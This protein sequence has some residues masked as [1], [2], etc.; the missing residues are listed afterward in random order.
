MPSWRAA[1]QV[2]RGCLAEAGSPARCWP[3]ATGRGWQQVRQ[4]ERHPAAQ[5]GGN[6]RIRIGHFKPDAERAAAGVE[7]PID[8][9]HQGLVFAADR[10]L[11]SDDGAITFVDLSI[12]TDRS[13]CDTR[14][15]GLLLS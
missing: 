3:S 11:R 5:I 9:R 12:I 10:V 2:S 8:H 14:W 4:L 15:A 13:C 1:R 7:N 6:R